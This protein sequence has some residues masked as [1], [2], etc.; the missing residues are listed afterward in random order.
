M[1]ESGIIGALRVTLGLDS[2]KFETG[3]GRAERKAKQVEGTLKGSFGRIGGYGKAMVSG[4]AVGFIGDQLFQLAKGG[5]EYAS[6]LGEV[7]KQVGVTSRTLQ[8]YRYAATQVGISQEEMDK[9]LAKLTR[10][11]GEAA[12]GASGPAKAF[13]TLGI[14]IRDANGQIKEAGDLMPE[15]AERLKSVGSEAERQALLVDLFGKS[16]QKMATLME[17]GAKGVE[18]LRKEAQELG[19]VLSDKDIA[20]ADKTADKITALQQALK[21]KVSAVVAENAEAIAGLVNK[22]LELV[23]ALGKLAKRWDESNLLNKKK[24]F[25]AAYIDKM[26]NFTTKQKA[27]MKALAN[28]KLDANAG[29]APDGKGSSFFGG[30]VKIQKVKSNALSGSTKFLGTATSAVPRLDADGLLGPPMARF[31]LTLTHSHAT[32]QDIANAAAPTAAA[33]SAFA[34][35][36]AQDELE[37]RKLNAELIDDKAAL[38]QI[39]KDEIDLRSKALIRDIQADKELSD[40]EKAKLVTVQQ[41]TAQAQKTLVDAAERDRLSD[42]EKDRVE[43]SLALAQ[44]KAQLAEAGIADARATLELE[45]QFAQTARARFYIQLQILQLDYEEEKARIE[46]AIAAGQVADAVTAR[47]NLEKRHV[48]R[49]QGLT[50]SYESDLQ[51]QQSAIIN[52]YTSVLNS[53]T[54]FAGNVK[55]GGFWNIL[56]GAVGVFSS[57]A[58]GGFLGGL[59]IKPQ[60]GTPGFARGGSMILGGRGGLDRNMLSL[61]GTPLARVSRGERMDI[62]P[63]G[64]QA[65]GQGLRIQVVKGDMFDVIVD[66]RADQRVATHAP[67][68]AGAG[69]S[70]AQTGMIKRA[71]KRLA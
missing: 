21:I 54:S 53:V 35:R 44:Q 46:T 11:I 36:V 8:E 41:Q 40:A 61:N 14:N 42:L 23:V 4:L 71:R 59:G 9:G 64:G 39:E 67:A 47:A 56:Q 22:V 20:N 15:I 6:S 5:L 2:S 70:I 17:G 33:L 43:E 30:L 45:N 66:H 1:S 27:E 16:G 19:V 32:V 63:A 55:K 10:T 28:D 52:S 18:G 3:V 48:L 49:V 68:I 58:Q 13:A 65:A 12:L 51:Q 31:A 37:L 62:V 25:A 60:G 29:R 24:D 7:A 38:A 57:L 26:P 69:A 50:K 34:E